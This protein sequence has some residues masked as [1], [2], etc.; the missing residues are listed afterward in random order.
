[1][2]DRFKDK[3]ETEIPLDAPNHPPTNS[4]DCL[5]AD[6]SMVSPVAVKRDTGS[7]TE[8]SNRAR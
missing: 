8:S 7:E 1:M 6:E 2:K 3:M 5:L 4:G